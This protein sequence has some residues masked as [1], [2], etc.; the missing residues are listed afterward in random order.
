MH[1]GLRSK[2]V[3][4]QFWQDDPFKVPIKMILSLDETK[5]SKHGTVRVGWDTLAAVCVH[6]SVPSQ[7]AL[8]H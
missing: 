6:E 1:A 2:K 7:A 4:L 8:E 3:Q 5:R